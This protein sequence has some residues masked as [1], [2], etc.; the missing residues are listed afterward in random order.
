MKKQK[1][2]TKNKKKTIIIVLVV[3]LVLISGVSIYFGIYFTKLTKPNRIV[4]LSINKLDN[5]ISSYIGMSNEYNLGDTFHVDST[6]TFDLDSEDYL[7]KSKTDKEYQ[8]K[9]K[10]IKNL[11]KTTNNISVIQD[12]KHKKLLLS[13]DSEL[14]KEKLLNAKYLPQSSC[15]V[16]IAGWK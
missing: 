16:S 9:Y 3:L 11:S 6:L 15:E 8:D 14:D 10:M 13:V 4:G 1:K 5:R 7:N 12:R 2:N